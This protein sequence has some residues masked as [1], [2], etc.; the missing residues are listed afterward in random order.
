MS[1][2]FARLWVV[3]SPCSPATWTN[4]TPRLSIMRRFGS[5]R[6]F[7]LIG[8]AVAIAPRSRD[9][10]VGL[11][12]RPRVPAA[13]NE[14]S[15]AIWPEPRRHTGVPRT[16]SINPTVP[17][18]VPLSV[19][20]ERQTSSGHPRPCHQRDPPTGRTSP[21]SSTATCRVEMPSPTTQITRARNSASIPTAPGSP[22]STQNFANQIIALVGDVNV[23][24]PINSYPSRVV[25]AR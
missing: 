23:S 21:S 17:A 2:R 25:E 13:F 16:R 7:G 8:W 6:E 10:L 24:G 18:T 22:L 1:Q 9:V 15:A 14:L 11:R 20:A 3:S 5:G 4:R 19:R 12:E